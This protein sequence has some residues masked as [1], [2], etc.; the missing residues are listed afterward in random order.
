MFK[1]RNRMALGYL[2]DKFSIHSSIHDRE[3]R[4]VNELNIPIFKTKSGQMI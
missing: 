3:T 1:C 2:T 4:N